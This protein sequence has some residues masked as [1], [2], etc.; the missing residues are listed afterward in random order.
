MRD[1][2]TSGLVESAL[3]RGPGRQG[4]A[5]LLA[6]SS[7]ALAL[8]PAVAA[9]ADAASDR[10]AT[11]SVG[12]L[13]VTAQKRDQTVK[14]VPS[15]VTALPAEQLQTAG[16][17]DAR[18]LVGLVPGLQVG[19][20][21]GA[22]EFSIRGLT[23]GN[24]VNPTVG[25][26]IDG[27]PIGPVAFGAGAAT[28]LPEIDPALISRV[29]VLRGPQ[30]TLYGGSTLGGIVNY[31]T[32]KPSLESVTG[33]VYLEGSGT[34][35]GTGNFVARA[36]LSAPIVQD[37]LAI[38]VSGFVDRLG[39]F[40]D[41]PTVGNNNYDYHHSYGGRAALLWQVSPD[42]QIEV[43][44][45]YSNQH[46]FQD[47]LVYNANGAP[48]DGELTSLTPVL[49]SFDA[50]FNMVSVNGSYDFHWATLSY[51]GTY[52]TLRSG[53]TYDDGN[54]KIAS[55]VANF[56][57]LF[58][59]VTPPSP[60]NIGAFSGDRA[61]KTT[62]E[63]RLT[64]PDQGRVR[65]LVGLFY[66]NEHTSNPEII[67]SYQLDQTISPGPA[68]DLIQYDLLTHLSEYAGFADVTVYVTPKL[69]V[70]GGVRVGYITQNFEQLY[71]GTDGAALNTLFT[72]L[73]LLPTPADTGV[74][75]SH[76]TFETW[77]ANVRYHLSPNDMVYF[78]FATGFRPGG[79]NDTVP[80][81]PATFAPDT[82][83]DFELGWKT[84]FWAGRGYFDLNLY[85]VE[86]NHIQILTTSN[87]LGGETNGGSATS[88]GVEANLSLRPVTGLSLAGTVAYSDGH[89]DQDAPGL[90]VAGDRLP[91]DPK[92]SGSFDADYAF[93]IR[94]EW[95]G[96]VGGTVRYNG[97]RDFTF[98]HNTLTPQ[99]VLPAYTLVD[100]RAGVRHDHLELTVFAR[101]VGDVRAQ[102][103]DYSSGANYVVINRPRTI[104]VSLA[105]RF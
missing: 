100:L 36:M 64:S 37:K 51:I 65:W 42:F 68:G 8:M 99:Y 15:A 98:D 61:V 91:N 103:G 62:Q 10:S 40:I 54:S 18:D 49:P 11:T 26:Q 93:P 50:R 32:R 48:R 16:A 101:N 9:A 63:I 47:V 35:H 17:T 76:E 87:G 29:E 46:A 27:A 59:G 45:L 20:G 6:G 5:A 83:Q 104:G 53:I 33:S 94:A 12:E 78:R 23:T 72:V 80:G 67:R 13:V 30:G 21:I 90:G 69:D 102:I 24:D 22:G 92:W 96:F 58:G 55:I 19:S 75:S 95:Q 44:D 86:W 31:V 41:D 82:T 105:A 88:R 1:A 52:Q 84:N 4:L 3:H 97:K 39:G 2:L 7:L 28:A 79:P 77:L 43:A 14:T 60:P 74:T 89:L 34:D 66:N 57:P 85:D 38:Q 70:T 56:L 71:G 81:L 25:L 73:G